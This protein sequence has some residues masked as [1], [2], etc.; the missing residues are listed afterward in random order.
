MRMVYPPAKGTAVV[1]DPIARPA[2]HGPG[3]S[4]C[5]RQVIAVAIAR[6]L[7]NLCRRPLTPHCPPTNGLCDWLR[8]TNAACTAH[9]Y[10]LHRGLLR[11]KDGH[12]D[13]WRDADEREPGQAMQ[14][15]VNDEGDSGR[16]AT[17]DP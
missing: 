12:V 5:P 17:P 6:L 14:V 16:T 1:V 8:C 11:H 9:L 2:A 13:S 4:P 3:R 7:C 10:D 15:D